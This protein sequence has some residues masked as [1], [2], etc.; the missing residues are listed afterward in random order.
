MLLG[1]QDATN[2]VNISGSASIMGQHNPAYPSIPLSSHAPYIIPS[3]GSTVSS[4]ASNS[5]S[6]I[7]DAKS[8]SKSG[9]Y[10]KDLV[11]PS[12]FFRTFASSALLMPPTSPSIPPAPLLSPRTVQPSH[13]TPLL[14]PYPPP[15]P[16]SYLNP[17]RFHSTVITRDKV[18][19]LMLRLVQVALVLAP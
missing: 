12:D 11:K 14:Q 1:L 6:P 13:G 16:S 2:T 10:S 5:A 19:H 17:N 15:A 3:A 9:N 4:A 7:H 18:H 8:V